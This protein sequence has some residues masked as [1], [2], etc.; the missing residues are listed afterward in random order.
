MHPSFAKEE[1]IYGII[2]N[3]TFFMF[4]SHIFKA[5]DIRGIYGTEVTEALAYDIGCAFAEF[6]K[7]D[8]GRD[9]LTL[10]VCQDMRTSSEPLKAEVIRGLTEQGI[11]VVD[12]G[13]AST[14]TFYFGVAK[15]G[16][17][18][19]IQVTAS[20]NPRL[21]NQWGKWHHGY[22]RYGRKGRISTG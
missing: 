17:D 6:M 13:L 19:G 21:F 1:E 20:H 5:Y 14:P 8:L 12:I 18:G 11:D 22:S 15:Y 2:Y 4:P 10:V 16:Y 3:S 9:D 7:K